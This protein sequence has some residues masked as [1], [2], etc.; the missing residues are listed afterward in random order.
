MVGYI[1][2]LNLIEEKKINVKKISHE[3]N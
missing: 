3:H 1:L 2:F